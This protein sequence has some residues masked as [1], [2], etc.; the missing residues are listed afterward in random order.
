MEILRQLAAGRFRSPGA[1][2]TWL[3]RIAHGRIIDYWRSRRR[4]PLGHA[5]SLEALQSNA[6][7][8]LTPASQEAR[9]MAEDALAA[10]PVRQRFLIAAHYRGDVPVP[11]LARML[12]LSEK[13]T[14]NLITEAKRL[15]RAY[16][17]G[18]GKAP[19]HRRLGTQG[20]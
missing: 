1:L 10:M 18:R 5:V 17:T 9:L 15:F 13:R 2:R 8:L 3:G 19:V 12:G 16:V 20:Q 6:P 4:R 11:E 14:R 7:R